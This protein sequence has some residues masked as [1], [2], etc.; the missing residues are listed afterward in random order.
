MTIKVENPQHLIGTGGAFYCMY[1]LHLHTN[2]YRKNC[3][4]NLCKMS[5][6]FKKYKKNKSVN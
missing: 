3:M 5:T 6:D 4:Q 1:F 2:L